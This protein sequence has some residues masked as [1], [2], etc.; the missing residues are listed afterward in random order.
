M[1]F[2]KLPLIVDHWGWEG[3][4][5]SPQLGFNGLH[6]VTMSPTQPLDSSSNV[7]SPESDMDRGIPFQVIDWVNVPATEHPG[8]PGM[9]HWQTV[10]FPGLRVRIVRYSPGY[11]A[12]HWCQKGHVVHCLE[13]GFETELESGDRFLLTQGMSYVVSDGLSSHRSYSEAGVVLLIVDG[14]FLRA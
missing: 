12:D 7:Q 6:F 13:G 10:Q 9:A 2:A 1:G 3:D 14:D 4:F 8:D 5:R 11:L